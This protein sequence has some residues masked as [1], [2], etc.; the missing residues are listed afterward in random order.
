MIVKHYD[1]KKNLNNKINF[2]LLY[3]NNRGFI[4]ETIK[5]VLK[6]IFSKN[7]IHYD[8]NEILNNQEILN[9]NI[10]NKSF[11]DNDK[12]I[13]IDRV[14]DKSFKILEEIIEK[15]VENIKIILSA[16]VLEKKSKLRNLFEKEKDLIIIPFYEDN[17]QSLLKIAQT[18]FR[19]K[20]IDISQQNINLIIERSKNDRMNLNN[21]LNKINNFILGK[22]KISS[23]EILKLTNL[24]ENYN[25]SELVDSCLSKNKKK[26][27]LILN[28]NYSSS[29]DN[30][31]ILKTFLYKLKRLKKIQLDLERERNIDVVLSKFKPIIF[32]KDKDTIKKQVQIW[33]LEHIQKLINNIQNIEL[34]VKKNPLISNFIINNFIFERLKA[35]N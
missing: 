12:L 21:E 4:D 24:A 31:L 22:K 20:K 25:I 16:G 30:I 27:I 18:F 5:F 26:T 19:D 33:S 34:L 6:P 8:E 29:E 14:S 28:E 3:G 1:L 32:W 35:S 11:F 7:I 13:I 23:D 10:F 17:Q 2:Y 9:E 15:K